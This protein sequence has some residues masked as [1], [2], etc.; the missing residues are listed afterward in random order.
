MNCSATSGLD[1]ITPHTPQ[2]SHIP[3]TFQTS[4]YYDNHCGI[5][6]STP[7]WAKSQVNQRDSSPKPKFLTYDFTSSATVKKLF[8]SGKSIIL[9]LRCWKESRKLRGGWSSLAGLELVCG[10]SP[11]MTVL[12]STFKTQGSPPSFFISY[13]AVCVADLRPSNPPGHLLSS[14]II[15]ASQHMT[16]VFRAFPAFTP[17]CSES[18]GVKTGALT[19]SNDDITTPCIPFLQASNPGREWIVQTTSP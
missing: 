9:S 14:L 16:T 2:T 4:P 1:L 15:V 13:Y 18:E 10:F 3:P 19:G 5:S 12:I 6:P 8:S 17:S 11:L 7:F